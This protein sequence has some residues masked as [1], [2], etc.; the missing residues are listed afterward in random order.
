LAAVPDPDAEDRPPFTPSAQLVALGETLRDY[1]DSLHISQEA[2]A[3]ELSFHRNYIGRV[4]RA[5]LNVSFERLALIADALG[6]RLGE[7]FELYEQHPEAKD[8]PSG[9][10]L[11]HARPPRR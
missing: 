8:K 7:L 11:Q 5:E 10:A 6:L 2:L 4:E 3:Q 1:R 9:R